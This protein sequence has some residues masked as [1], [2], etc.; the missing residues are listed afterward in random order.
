[1]CFPLPSHP[2]P[3]SNCLKKCYFSTQ[4]DR[5][6]ELYNFNSYFSIISLWFLKYSSCIVEC[7]GWLGTGSPGQWL[8]HQAW[9]SSSSIWTGLRGT[10]CD[11]GGVLCRGRRLTQ[12]PWRHL[13]NSGYSLIF[14]F[15]DPCGALPMQDIPMTL[16]NAHYS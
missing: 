3:R 7:R 1:M 9:Q 11:S 10:R 14:W 5:T 8:Q 6:G 15:Y 12:W 2:Q 4:N 16:C 13:S